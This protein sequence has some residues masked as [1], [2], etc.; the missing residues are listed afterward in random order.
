M[1]KVPT[2]EQIRK[3]VVAARI[4]AEAAKSYLY[5]SYEMLRLGRGSSL[6][7]LIPG[8]SCGLLRNE[9]VARF[10]EEAI[11]PFGGGH[12]VSIG[13]APELDTK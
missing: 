10:I 11:A 7:I 3:L 9:D 4:G 13:Q 6:E 1:S 8:T 12:D 5:Y 2:D